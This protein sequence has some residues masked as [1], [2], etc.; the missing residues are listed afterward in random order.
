M[1]LI[2]SRDNEKDNLNVIP[3]ATVITGKDGTYLFDGLPPGEYEVRFIHPQGGVIY[4]YPV[5]DEPGVDLAAGTIRKLILEGGEH[6][7]EQNLPIDPSGVV[8]DSET[9]ETVAGATVTLVAPPGFDADRDLIGGQDN[10]SQITGEDGLY[11][12]LFFTSAPSGVYSLTI[13]EPMGYLAG[14]ST[15]IPPVLIRQIF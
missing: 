11:Q 14:T 1:Q 4:G 7:D 15:L 10:M 12:F 9:R 5:S 8:Y 2:D 3:I 13:V 6:I